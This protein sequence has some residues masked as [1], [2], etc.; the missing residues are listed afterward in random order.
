MDDRTVEA[1]AVSLNGDGWMV[2]RG[3]LSTGRTE[4]FHAE[5]WAMRVAPRNSVTRA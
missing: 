2:I 4:V 3:Y 5:L 1:A